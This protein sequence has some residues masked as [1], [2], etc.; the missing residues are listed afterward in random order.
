[1]PQYRMAATFVLA[2]CSAFGGGMLYAAS[3]TDA[4]AGWI[5]GSP[6]K[7][8]EPRFSYDAKGGREGAGAMVIEAD[9]REGLDGFW[10]H[11]YPVTGG[12]FYEFAVFRRI[13]DVEW[14]QQNGV[15]TIRWTDA[16]G[17]G[18]LD[19]GPLV[20]GYLKRFTPIAPREYPRDEQ[21]DSD[22]WT[23]VSG[24]YR[25][26]ATA[27]AAIVQLHLR[28]AR[29]A[30]VEWSGA[31]LREVDTPQP[32]KVRLAAIHLQ[33]GG[34]T[35]DGNRKAYA[36]L[37]REA[38]RQ[39]ADLVVLGETITYFRTGLRPDEAAEPV[40]GPSTVYFGQLARENNL[41]IV[42]GLYERVDHLV[43]NVAVLISPEGKVI[44]KYRKTTLP[45]GEAELGVAPGLDYPVFQTRFGK[46]GMMI[47]YDGFFPEVARELT[48]R[49]AEV[50]AWPIWG[51]NPDVARARAADNHVYLVSSTYEDVSSNWM[52]SA[53]WDHSGATPAIAKDWGTV[54]VAEV[55]LNE[56][57]RWRSLGDFRSKL[58]RHVPLIQP[59]TTFR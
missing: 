35:P 48:K 1:M 9:A 55:D 51:G 26:P 52:F 14:P 57:T 3:N 32:R 10:S 17:K 28:W 49:G 13:S 6:R 39:K 43:Y 15:V 38:G 45:D 59:E 31:T 40:P 19:D 27:K 42:V 11:T 21:R 7:Q 30:R 41:H 25:A 18:V 54:V 16:N 4:P 37:I 50:I 29:N 34:K 36:P 47:C 2:A 8:I 20:E 44:G 33:P 53:V 56:Q 22:G 5:T 24:T 23:R 58:P 46:V 12:K